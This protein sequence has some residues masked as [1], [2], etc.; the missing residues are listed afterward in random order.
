[1]FTITIQELQQKLKL[2]ESEAMEVI[3]PFSELPPLQQ[4]TVKQ[5]ILEL[6][7]HNKKGSGIPRPL[8]FAQLSG[9]YGTVNKV[10]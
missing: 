1:M 7:S 8:A 10:D 9:K 2:D 6:A 5:R 3:K 4:R